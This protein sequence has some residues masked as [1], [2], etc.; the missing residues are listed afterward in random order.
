MRLARVFLQ[1]WRERDFPN[2]SQETFGQRFHPPVDKG[3][4]S[5][6]ENAKP[7]HLTLGVIAAYAEALGRRPAEMYR[8]PPKTDADAP[9]PSLDEMADDMGVDR[10]V[11]ID[12]L[13]AVQGRR[14]G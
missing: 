2:I 3:T 12:I 11:V 13:S 4:I 5:R 9:Q 8:P 6:W 14:A 10:K 1:A 7:G